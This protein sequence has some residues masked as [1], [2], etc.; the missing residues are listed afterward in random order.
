MHWASALPL[1]PR[2]C[3]AVLWARDATPIPVQASLSDHPMA[4]KRTL[5]TRSPGKTESRR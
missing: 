1:E 5:D 2:F 4:G 3:L